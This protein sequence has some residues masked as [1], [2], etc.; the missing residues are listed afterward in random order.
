MEARD[1]ATS[2]LRI[3]VATS[4]IEGGQAVGW[5]DPDRVLG[6]VAFCEPQDAFERFVLPHLLDP[7]LPVSVP[8]TLPPSV[9]TLVSGLEAAHHRLYR[10]NHSVMKDPQWVRMTAACAEENRI[11]FVRTD[12]AWLYL[13]RDGRAHLLGESSSETPDW[14]DRSLALGGPENLRLQVTSLGV[15]PDD[16]VLL[17]SGDAQEPPDL[18]A[19]ARLFAESRDLKRASDGVVNLLGLQGPSAAVV[20]FRFATLLPGIE[21]KHLDVSRGEAVLGEIT[22]MA[23]EMVFGVTAQGSEEAAEI[24]EPAIGEETEAQILFPDFGA[25]SVESSQPVGEPAEFQEP[26]PGAESECAEVVEPPAASPEDLLATFPVAGDWPGEGSVPRK[27]TSRGSAWPVIVVAV[28]LFILAALLMSGGA[29][30]GVVRTLRGFLGLNESPGSSVAS[31]TQITAT[32][33]PDGATVSIDGTKL[34]GKTPLKGVR[35]PGGKH[36]VVMS[37]GAAG[38]WADSVDWEEGGDYAL[39]ARFLGS[40]EISAQDLSGEPQAWLAGQ[41]TKMTLPARLDSLPA[42][43]YRVF[44]ED[45]KIPL[46]ERKVL[47]RHAETARVEVNNDFA[48]EKV[49]VRVESSRMIESEGLRPVEG[50]SVFV[51]GDWV[52][53]TPLELELLPGLHG[54]CVQS[55]G[56]EYCEILRLPAGASRFITPQFGLRERPKFAHLPPG[57]AVAQ[58]G[59]IFLAVDIESARGGLR[60][61]LLHLPGGP[62]HPQSVPLVQVGSGETQFVARVSGSWLR[63]GIEMPYFFSVTTPEGEEVFSRLFHL[64]LVETPAELTENKASR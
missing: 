55:E 15:Q 39:S 24:A 51:D 16:E 21:D 13:L 53:L 59:Q 36:Y 29:W 17:V 6:C 37:L 45:Q 54:V 11:F 57:Q 48:A 12:S 52:G 27:R 1:L 63:T 41:T 34:L 38:V 40:L 23:R 10:E 9:S 30:P 50:D 2:P 32:S 60:Y 47:V 5:A 64:E 31:V 56:E 14:N 4:Q 58:G 25:G 28:L 22:D 62:D 7:E 35:V 49:L 8:E 44:F 26:I 61:P 46:W 19:I 33:E 18:R 3:E 20:A 42:G 43:W